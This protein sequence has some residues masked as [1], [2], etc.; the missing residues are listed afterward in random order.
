MIP[1]LF[2]KIQRPQSSSSSHQSAQARCALTATLDPPIAAAA[3][4]PRR[5]HG[6]PHGEGGMERQ[7]RRRRQW[8]PSP[9]L[10]P[11]TLLQQ[12]H[13]APRSVRLLHLHAR[14]PSPSPSLRGAQ[15]QQEATPPRH[16]QPPHAPPR[17]PPRPQRCLLCH[18]VRHRPLHRTRRYC[19]N[20]GSM[21]QI[22]T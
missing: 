14:P 16:G 2:V 11:P 9:C 5:R 8:G 10:L 20:K 3:A 6:H 17:P 19:I 12:H 21:T 1:S 13:A 7:L 22:T 15:A 18:R 4:D